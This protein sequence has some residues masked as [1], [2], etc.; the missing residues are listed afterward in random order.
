MY[1]KREMVS[2]G[3]R[4]GI[5]NLP[6]HYGKVPP[7]LFGRM[8]QLAREITVVT[9]TEFGTRE[10]LRRLSDPY[11][12]Q[13]FGCVL[14]YDWHSSGVTTTVCGALKEGLRGLEKDLGLFVAGGKGRTS[15][16]TPAEIETSGHLLKVNPSTLVYASRM[17]AKVDNSALQDGYQLYHH[18]FFFTKE[19]SW[20]VIQQGMNEA[21]R[22]ARRY[23]WLGEKVSDF[24]CEP[25]AAICSQAK[26][27]AVNLVA[28][29]S[30]KA[31]DVITQVATKD[32]PNKIVGQLNRLKTLNLPQ[33]AYVSLKDIHPD[34]LGKIFLSAYEHKPKNFESLLALDGMG[35]KTLRA[36]SLISEL[37][38]DTP[39]SLRDPA[40]YSFAHGGKDGYP[41]PVDRKTYDNSIQ[42]LT[43]ALEKAKI[44]DS[45]KLEAFRRLRA[46]K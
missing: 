38:Y 17:S 16:R 37:V 41:Y 3:Q 13:A 7:W 19:G 20:A 18:C 46:W 36:L 2:S 21:N 4:T 39:V 12:F 43:Q 14:G 15:R 31:R 1:W 42:F 25:E 30:A 40:S 29:E 44:G 24:V 23:H 22:Y 28:T 5:A 33:R 32:R 9:L 45:E 35:P 27:E 8:S 6:L 10:M 34:R 11:W 26:G